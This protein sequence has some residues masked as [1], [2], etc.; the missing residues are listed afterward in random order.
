MLQRIPKL[1]SKSKH[2]VSELIQQAVRM[3]QLGEIVAFPTDTVYGLGADPFNS[4]AVHKLFNCKGRSSNKPIPVLVSSIEQAT[5]VVQETPPLFFQ[6]AKQHWP[7][8][9]TIILPVKPNL[10]KV[11]TAGQT[12]IG[13]RIPANRLACQLIQHFGRPIATT[14]ANLSDHPPATTALQV[15]QQLGNNL[16]VLDGGPTKTQVSSTVIDLT[17]DSPQIRRQGAV[18]LSLDQIN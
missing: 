8:A 5:Q 2:T 16:L 15:S 9:L 10:P 6:L 12:T 7:G 1:V 11:V 18:T 3:L 17:T 13:I 4:I 14:S